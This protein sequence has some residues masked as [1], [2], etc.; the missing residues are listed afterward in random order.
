METKT[1]RAV[2]LLD[3]RIRAE[4]IVYVRETEERMAYPIRNAKGQTPWADIDGARHDLTEREVRKL[5]ELLKELM[6]EV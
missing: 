3:G 6:T 1:I 4:I 5:K 2:K